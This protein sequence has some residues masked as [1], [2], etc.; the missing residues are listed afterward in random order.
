[1][2]R[3]M[4]W[5]SL[6]ALGIALLTAAPPEA[7][8]RPRPKIEW[9]RVDVPEGPDAA[10]RAK[11]FKQALAQAARRA[12]F[13]K[14]KAVSLSVRITELTLERH[15]DV[16]HVHCTAMGRIKGGPGAR[17]K[18]SFGGDPTKQVD[19]ENQVLTMVA[20]GLVARL[21]QIVRDQG[22]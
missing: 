22:N 21:A 10:R 9:V 4:T 12:S 15:E 11:L 2:R 18:I 3:V 17:S 8:A 5:A 1:M 6:V 7:A 19:L 13:G 16:L 20:N 14:A